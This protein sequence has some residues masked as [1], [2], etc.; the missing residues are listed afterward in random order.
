MQSLR[1]LFRPTTSLSGTSLPGFHMQ[2][3]WGSPGMLAWNF[4][5]V[6]FLS[7]FSSLQYFFPKG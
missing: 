4:S 2:P 3:P 5:H 7:Y 1:D 6:N